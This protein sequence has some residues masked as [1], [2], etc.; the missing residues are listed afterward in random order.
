MHMPDVQAWSISQYYSALGAVRIGL[1]DLEIVQCRVL[2][3][4]IGLILK[5]ILL[6]FR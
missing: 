1:D 2:V 6:M 4:R 3:D 5:G